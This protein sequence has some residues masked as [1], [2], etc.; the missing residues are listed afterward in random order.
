MPAANKGVFV[1]PG[2]GFGVATVAVFYLNQG[3]PEESWKS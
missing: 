3:K 2:Q 1:W